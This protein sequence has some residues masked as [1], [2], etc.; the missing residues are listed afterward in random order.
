MILVTGATGTIG[1]E[2]VRQLAARGEKVRALTRDPA[3]ARVPSGVE[4]VPGH[5]GDRASVEGAMAGVAAAFLVGVF[6]PD[7]AE[8]DRGMAEA[9]RAAGV[10]R[11]VKLSSIGT[12]DPRLAGFG[13]WHL[14]GEEA[15]R[16]SGLEWAVLRPSSFASNTLAWADAVREGTPAPNLMG[17]GKQGVVDPG[18]VAEVAVRTLLEPGHTGRTYTLTGPET[19]SASG[20]ATVLGE[21]LGRPV[22]LLSL[23]ADQRREQLLGAGLGADYADSLMAGARFIEEGGNALVTDDVPEVLRRPA[24]SYREWAED[25]RT[26]FGAE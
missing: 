23:T 8:Q 17:E 4:A 6:G 13:R 19:I 18:D 22:T 9:A 1:S 2:V 15:V 7:D 11:I 16:G 26:A 24:R 5:P 21:I 20:Q 10:R 3:A 25:H 14:P 12:G